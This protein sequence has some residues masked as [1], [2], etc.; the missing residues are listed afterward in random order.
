MGRYNEAPLSNFPDEFCHLSRMTDPDATVL[1]L[2]VEYNTKSANGDLEGCQALLRN[3]P[4]LAD[5]Q[6]S[7]LRMNQLLDEIVAT[8]KFFLEEVQTFINNI[9]Q[10][11]V[12]I[13]DTESVNI[14]EQNFKPTITN[15]EQTLSSTSSFSIKGIFNIV[16]SLKSK[17]DLIS[18]KY[19]EALDSLKNETRTQIGFIRG[20]M[21]SF[22]SERNSNRLIKLSIPVNSWKVPENT[23]FVGGSSN[24]VIAEVNNS[25][26]K[27]TDNPILVKYFGENP[28]LSNIKEYNKAF[29]Y[30]I[31]GNV[32]N[33]KVTFVATKKP[34]FNLTIALKG[35]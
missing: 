35:V 2:I 11:K 13:S 6:F 31:A 18:S 21:V 28:N 3:N 29:S 9:A 8:Q 14:V 30:I 26:L 27:S 22:E 16:K 23:M 34:N 24:M 5:C 15:Y 32:D 19:N 20:Q 1:K 4:K 17:I 33:G 25:Q 7:S 12:G 10:N